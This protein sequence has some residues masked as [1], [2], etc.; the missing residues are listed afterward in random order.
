MIKWED[1]SSYQRG[2]K[3]RVPSTLHAIVG[4]V[5]IVV[6]RHIHYPGKW[7]ASVRPFFEQRELKSL[8][9]E[10]AKREAV[11]LASKWICDCLDAFD[12]AGI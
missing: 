5:Q 3:E 9:L 8:D 11:A 4:P 1:I 10:D 6:T 12:R 7:L 2:D